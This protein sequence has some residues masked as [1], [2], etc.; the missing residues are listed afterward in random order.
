MTSIKNSTILITGGASGIGKLMGEKMLRRGATQVVI[1]DINATA[2]AATVSEWRVQ[3]FE[4]HG[5]VANVADPDSVRTQAAR[6]LSEVGRVDILL[7]NAGIVAGGEF[8]QQSHE[9]I[10]RTLDV[11]VSG[12]MHVARAFLPDMLHQRRGH[13]VNISS[14]SGLIPVPG[15]A[16]YAGSKWAVLGWSE[17]LRLELARQRGDLY[18]TTVTPG[19]IDTG[20]FAGV[21]PPM[22]TPLLTPDEIT[23]KILTAIERNRSL[24]RAPESV[25]LLPILRGLLPTHLFDRWVGQALGIYDSMASF[26]GRKPE[27]AEAPAKALK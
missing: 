27:E 8:S 15:L 24:V 21:T 5:Y 2:L 20:M 4:A 1:W 11:N 26:V 9:Q 22:L 14:A 3:G 7:N 23:D 17:S 19:Y 13:I 16:V 10:Q 25:Y 12:A 6:T 18:V